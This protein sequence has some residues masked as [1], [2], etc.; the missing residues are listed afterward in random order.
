M[1]K[2]LFLCFQNEIHLPSRLTS[3]GITV[4]CADRGLYLHLEVAA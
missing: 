1:L 3:S 2:R 4:F